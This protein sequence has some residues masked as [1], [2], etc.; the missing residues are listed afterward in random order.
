MTPFATPDLVT[1]LE[2]YGHEQLT[3]GR[4]PAARYLGIL[5]IHS[6]ALGPAVGGTRFW[7]YPSLQ[8]ALI[9]A[10]RLSRGMTYKNALAGL[11]FGGG[12][13]VL[14]V[15]AAAGGS[16]RLEGPARAAFFR[17]HGRFIERLNGSYITAEDVGTSPADMALIAT[18]TRWV[19]GLTRGVGDPSPFTA[20]GVCRAIEAAAHAVWGT[21]R[22]A[23]RTIAI[24]GLGNVGRHLAAQLD[25][26]GARLIVADIDAARAAAVVAAHGATAVSPDAVLETEADV[27]APCALG[28]ILND[29]TIPR[30][31]AAVVAG[32]ANNQLLDARHGDAL[33]ARGILYVPDYV[34]NAGGVI[35]GTVDIAGWD[36][37]RMDAQ[38]D[39]I[40]ATV[41]EVLAR[42]REWGVAP[43]TAA[44]RLAE[45]RIAAARRI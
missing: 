16:P 34:A 31:R 26:R 33:A 17:A 15:L 28:G 3:I 30:L 9:D 21:D 37:A 32:A 1:A 25:A 12:K 41:G 22:L 2:Q 35:S 39:G 8:E 11:P 42:A 5:A 40:Y 23:G 6:T 18:E 38:L 29:D 20:A 43:Q 7:T 36:R 10:L 14:P 13:S 27:L 4:D 24:Q 19:A 45:A 44:D